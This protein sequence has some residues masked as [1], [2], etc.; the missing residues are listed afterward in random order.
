M[1]EIVLADSLQDIHPNDIST[2]SIEMLGIDV[3]NVLTD[4]GD[5]EVLPGIAEHLFGLEAACRGLKMVLITNNSDRGFLKDVISQLPSEISYINPTQTGLKKKP[6]SSMFNYAA[7]I[8]DV[9]PEQAAHID[10][11][12]K[13]WLGANRAGYGTF[14]WTKPVGSRQHTAVK[15]F[16]PVE[17]GA[18]RPAIRTAHWFA[19]TA[20]VTKY[21]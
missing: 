15:A 12:S 6:S 21:N 9:N 17:F 13:A 16:R 18:I 7:A 3:E 2:R 11:Q 19:V 5:P 8:F 1:T 20:N 4:F 14:F 10:D